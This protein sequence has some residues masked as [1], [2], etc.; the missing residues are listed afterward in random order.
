MSK[1]PSEEDSAKEDEEYLHAEQAKHPE[2]IYKCYKCG[3]TEK[4]KNLD[5][6]NLNNRDESWYFETTFGDVPLTIVLRLLPKINIDIVSKAKAYC[7]V[8]GKIREREV[9]L[10]NIEIRKVKAFEKIGSAFENSDNIVITLKN[11][12]TALSDIAY[13]MKRFKRLS[14]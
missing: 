1:L 11:I 5:D 10:L 6:L 8:C 13:E 4:G 2:K 14:E 7:D 12:G 9:E 3:K